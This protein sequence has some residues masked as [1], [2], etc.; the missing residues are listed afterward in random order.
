M[1]G[2]VAQAED[3][4]EEREPEAF[5]S[6]LLNDGMKGAFAVDDQCYGNGGEDFYLC[7]DDKWFQEWRR[8]ATDLMMLSTA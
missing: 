8:V 2:V 4:E 3:G 7:N 5:G 1:K 6:G